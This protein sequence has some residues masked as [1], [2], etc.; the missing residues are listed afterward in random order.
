MAFLVDKVGAGM[1]AKV[2]EEDLAMVDLCSPKL[3]GD[4]SCCTPPKR[5]SG[6]L[7]PWCDTAAEAEEDP[8][9]VQALGG[10]E[11]TPAIDK[12]SKKVKA[13][14]WS[15]CKQ[16]PVAASCV[17]QK[18]LAVDLRGPIHECSIVKAAKPERAYI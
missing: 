13:P 4:L 11:V 14:R 16:Q 2:C 10:Q 5:A 9:Y 6:A 18:S 3:L 7:V 8:L 12:K 15:H 17:P 1:E